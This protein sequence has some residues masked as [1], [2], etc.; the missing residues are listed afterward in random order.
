MRL[1]NR[2][3]LSSPGDAD[4]CHANNHNHVWW[5]CPDV[6][7]VEG[8]KSGGLLHFRVLTFLLLALICLSLSAYFSLV[9][10]VEDLHFGAYFVQI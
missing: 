3:S 6:L 2:Q 7:D 9:Y 1:G 8:N 4:M 10:T 5:T